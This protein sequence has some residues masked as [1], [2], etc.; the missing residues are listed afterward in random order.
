MNIEMKNIESE[1]DTKDISIADEQ[2]KHQS[3]E[4]HVMRTVMDEFQVIFTEFIFIF[5][6]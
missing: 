4:N 1:M 5:V 3:F 2:R 6:S